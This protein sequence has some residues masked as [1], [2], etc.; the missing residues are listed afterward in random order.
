MFVSFVQG[1]VPRLL[2][3]GIILVAL[4]Q[5]LFTELR[6]ADVTVQ[7][8][9]ALAAAAGAGGGSQKG[10]LAGFVLGLMYDLRV[11]SPIGSSSLTMG[12]AGFTAGYVTSITI[13]PQWWLAGLFTALGAAVGEALVPVVRV[14]IGEEY[15]LSYRLVIVV[16]VVAAA[17]FVMSPLLVPLGR[18][19]MKVKRT[20]WT[21]VETAKKLE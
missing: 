1:P 13:D 14:F 10:A 12:V 2:L 21:K 15:P 16:T 8:V 6:P 19:C 17:A 11:G 9:L 5:T 7:V 4:Q 18:W 3:V 20:D